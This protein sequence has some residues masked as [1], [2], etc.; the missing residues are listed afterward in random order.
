MN[1]AQFTQLGQFVHFATQRFDLP[2]LAG[3]WTDARPQPEIPGRAVGLSLVL[4][5]VVGIPSFLQLEQETRLP[6]W[7]RW[8]GYPGPISHAT[9]G[10]VAERLDPAPLRRV[11]V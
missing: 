4:G 3:G 8:A 10:Y 6:Q 2:L 7:Q 9:F 11:G 5:E 1:S